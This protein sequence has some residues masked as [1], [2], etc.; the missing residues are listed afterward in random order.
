MLPN[1]G[2]APIKTIKKTFK[3][4]TQFALELPDQVGLRHSLKSAN[5]VL[6]IPCRQEPVATN[7]V[8]ADPPA[9]DDGSMCAQIFVG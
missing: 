2:W 7:T 5:P 3:A 8:F 6:N 4:S 1:F 9:V